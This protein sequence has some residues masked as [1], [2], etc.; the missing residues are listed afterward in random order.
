MSDVNKIRF[1]IT[2]SKEIKDWFTDRAD[3]IG[4][5][6]SALMTIALVQYKEQYEGIK[7]MSNMSEY[8]EQI[9]ALQ[10]SMNENNK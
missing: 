4:V 2:L 5:P 3:A 6:T 1:N 8:M 9:Q 10:G 7:A